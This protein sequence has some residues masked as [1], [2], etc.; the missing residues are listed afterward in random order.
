MDY[1]AIT[2]GLDPDIRASLMYR[3]VAVLGTH[4]GFKQGPYDTLQNVLART[5][6]NDRHALLIFQ[7]EAFCDCSPASIRKRYQRRRQGF[8]LFLNSFALQN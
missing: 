6:W 4:A 7:R 1:R 8:V 3:C 5:A 2:S